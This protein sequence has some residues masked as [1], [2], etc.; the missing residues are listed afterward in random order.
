MAMTLSEWAR[1]NEI[2]HRAIL[3]RETAR[4]AFV[5]RECA[6]NA[7][8]CAE[9]ESL[10][11]CRRTGTGLRTSRTKQAVSRSTSGG[12][13]RPRRNGR[14]RRREEAPR[15]GAPTARNFST[16]RRTDS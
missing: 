13:P 4:D 6:G 9:V 1:A 5:A 3:L 15:D 16:S 10:V 12:F 11:Q 2:F 7:E 8:L 14:C